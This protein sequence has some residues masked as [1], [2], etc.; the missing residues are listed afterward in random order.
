MQSAKN[1]SHSGVIIPSSNK[2]EYNANIS[3]WV[4]GLIRSMCEK[5]SVLPDDGNGCGSLCS[6]NHIFIHLTIVGVRIPDCSLANINPA[7]TSS[8]V[9]PCRCQCSFCSSVMITSFNK[10][11]TL[12]LSGQCERALTMF[13]CQIFSKVLNPLSLNVMVLPSARRWVSVSPILSIYFFAPIL[14]EFVKSSVQAV[15]RVRPPRD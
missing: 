6:A 7:S 3:N 12:R 8:R 15:Q 10:S 5:S 11:N 4:I 2:K 13:V 9:M 1:D 14:I